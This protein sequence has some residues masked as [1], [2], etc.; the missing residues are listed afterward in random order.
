LA[1]PRRRSPGKR[2]KEGRKVSNK[3]GRKVGKGK[4]GRKVGKEGRKVS[5]SKKKDN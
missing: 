2:G 1:V 3:E 4:E 5:N